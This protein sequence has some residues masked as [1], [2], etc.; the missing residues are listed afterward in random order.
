MVKIYIALVICVNCHTEKLILALIVYLLGSILL[1]NSCI[2][3]DLFD[4]RQ[5][6]S[7]SIIIEGLQM[8]LLTWL[9]FKS[10]IVLIVTIALIIF[11]QKI[12]CIKPRFMLVAY[13]LG[14]LYFTI[15]NRIGV[16]TGVDTPFFWSLEN[17]GTLPNILNIFNNVMLFIPLG[18]ILYR[19][20]PKW[21]AVLIGIGFS[22]AIE[23][24]QLITTIGA[25]EFN[26]LVSNSLGTVIGFAVMRWIMRREMETRG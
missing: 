10:G 7:G 1:R 8:S 4:K 18:A 5:L 16:L 2:E 11:I 9:Y 6:K 3:E 24:A 25:C 21:R 13:A 14:I 22:V 17:I 19:M 12:K 26:D 15:L 20:L 23:V